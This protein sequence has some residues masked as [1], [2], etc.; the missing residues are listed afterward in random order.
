MRCLTYKCKHGATKPKHDLLFVRMYNIYI[1][2][3]ITLGVWVIKIAFC[4]CVCVC[5]HK[6]AANMLQIFVKAFFVHFA[7]GETVNVL[8]IILCA[9][10]AVIFC[11]TFAVSLI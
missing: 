6:R 3:S 8:T 5:F 10:M 4:L 1:Y 11:F 2:I 7:F 9:I